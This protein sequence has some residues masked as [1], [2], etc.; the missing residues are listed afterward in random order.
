MKPL[1]TLGECVNEVV[2]EPSTWLK[3]GMMGNVKR[4]FCFGIPPLSISCHNLCIAMPCLKGKE[5]WMSSS[6]ASLLEDSNVKH[7]FI[8]S[9]SSCLLKIVSRVAI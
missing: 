3:G 8:E 6:T 7:R 1:E 4:L 5:E 9:S 2:L